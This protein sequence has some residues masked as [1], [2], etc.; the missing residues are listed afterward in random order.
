MSNKSHSDVQNIMVKHKNTNQNSEIKTKNKKICVHFDIL[1]CC[2]AFLLCFSQIEWIW[3]HKWIIRQKIRINRR[4]ILNESENSKM[5]MDESLPPSQKCVLLPY[6]ISCR[7]HHKVDEMK[8][9]WNFFVERKIKNSEWEIE[10]KIIK[11]LILFDGK[12]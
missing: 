6:S 1:W 11:T 2:D 10:G 7:L 8:K 4:N 12:N 5:A 9:I 3:N